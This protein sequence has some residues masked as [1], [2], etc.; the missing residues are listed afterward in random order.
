MLRIHMHGGAYLRS[1]C[2]GDTVNG[3][4]VLGLLL[5]QLFSTSFSVLFLCF[6]IDL[7]FRS[8]VLWCL[9]MCAFFIVLLP[10]FLLCL[11]LE[12]T[13]SGYVFCYVEG[14]RFSGTRVEEKSGCRKET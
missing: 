8:F 5:L 7:L 2:I 12:R 6:F 9:F 1:G 10:T 14:S 3:C 4:S 11:L 13:F